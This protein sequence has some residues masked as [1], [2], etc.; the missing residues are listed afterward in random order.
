MPQNRPMRRKRNDTKWA[1][2]PKKQKGEREGTNVHKSGACDE[3]EMGVDSSSKLQH[4]ISPFQSESWI[5]KTK[6][7]LGCT[8]Y[9]RVQCRYPVKVCGEREECGCQSVYPLYRQMPKWQNFDRLYSLLASGWQLSFFSLAASVA[10]LDG[11]SYSFKLPI[12]NGVGVAQRSII[13]AKTD[14]C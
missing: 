9:W 1:Y 6:E 10:T 4:R 14:H 3:H 13:Q 7:G 5:L 8:I 12:R 11:F 2:P